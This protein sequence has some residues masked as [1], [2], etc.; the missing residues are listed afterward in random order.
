MKWN[1][2]VFFNFNTFTRARKEAK[3]LEKNTKKAASTVM[4]KMA[5]APSADEPLPHGED[6]PAVRINVHFDKDL[7]DEEKY[8]EE[9]GTK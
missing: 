5:E 2:K 4:T 8:F 7:N 9:M 6:F 1:N 3:Q